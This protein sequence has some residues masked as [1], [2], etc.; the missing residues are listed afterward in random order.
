MVRV[1]IPATLRSFCGG[2]SQLEVDGANIGQVLRAL[3]ERCPGF[4]GRVVEEGRLRPELAFALN[5]EVVP[6]ALHT[7]VTPETE[8][9]IVPA[10]GGGT[11]NSY[12]ILVVGHSGTEGYGLD[13]RR[14]A[15]PG[16]LEDLLRDRELDCE[17]V[18]VPLFPV[19]NKAISYAMGQVERH[20]PDIVILSLNAY[21]CAV[22]MVSARV[23]RKFGNRAHGAFLRL[24]RRF[25]RATTG[26]SGSSRERVNSLGRRLTRKV[27]G[28]E[29]IA[30]LDEVAGVYAGIM[31]RLA[32]SEGVQV[33]ALQEVPFSRRLRGRTPQA[34]VIARE[35]HRRLE[36]IIHEHRFDLVRPEGF[37]S[38]LADTGWLADGIHLSAEGNVAYAATIA[39]AILSVT[40][41]RVVDPPPKT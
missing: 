11:L 4:Y 41:H 10:L 33:L 39:S 40:A 26:P 9:A 13:G 35:L 36:P 3:D 38:E 29:P 23:Q 28:A 5:G 15:W 19:G 24:E 7:E 2:S 17:L 8:I 6:L 25:E 12:R 1:I 14:Q 30:S 22:S 32:Q 16:L 31:K 21:P 34:A 20:Q 37:D 27:L 18:A